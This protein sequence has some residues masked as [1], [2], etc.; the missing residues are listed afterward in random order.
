MDNDTSVPPPRVKESPPDDAFVYTPALERFAGAA[1]DVVFLHII[2]IPLRTPAADL[3]FQHGT[4]LPAVIFTAIYFAFLLLI[5][6]FRGLTPGGL[7][8]KYRVFD[9]QLNRLSWAAALRRLSPYIIIQI[10]GLW[11]LQVVLGN[12]ADS[13]ED[14][15]FEDMQEIV[16]QHGGIW[17]VLVVALNSFVLMDLLL[18]IPSPRNQSL[19]DRFA[20]SVVVTRKT[21]LS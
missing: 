15:V 19:S 11:R 18:I 4:I 10:V 7:P 14:Y 16:K 21:S 6:R 13:G 9:G 17:N 8:L 5:L 2:L 12:F 3:S 1:M 20:A